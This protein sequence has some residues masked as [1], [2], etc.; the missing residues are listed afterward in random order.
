MSKLKLSN[1]IT[2]TVREPMRCS[3]TDQ[4]LVDRARSLAAAGRDI[5]NED[6]SQSSIKSQMRSKL[7]LLHAQRNVL[8]DVVASSSEY[9]EVSVVESHDYNTG[10]IKRTRIDTGEIIEEREMV[11]EERQ[12]PLMSVERADAS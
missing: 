6:A 10:I 1:I 9:R 2:R 5:D 7:K 11:D 3:L 8:N 4:E 12:M